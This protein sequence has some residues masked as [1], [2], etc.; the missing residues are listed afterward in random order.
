[1]EMNPEPNN[2]Q[3][4]SYPAALR[5]W[6]KAKWKKIEGDVVHIGQT[7]KQ[8][9]KDDPRRITHSFKVGLAISLVSLFYYF[10]PLYEGLGVNAM[11]AVLT[12]VV[13]FEYSVGKHL[14]VCH[15]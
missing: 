10:D 9:A 12:V 15:K 1:M 5:S 13:I 2:E 14:F 8:L 3:S 11:W 7:A 4:G 6:F